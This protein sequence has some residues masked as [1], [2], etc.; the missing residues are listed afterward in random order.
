M[1]EKEKTEQEVNEVNLLINEGIKFKVTYN[2]RKKQGFLKKSVT[3]QI[4]E[5]F[6]IKE[7][8]LDTLDRICAIAVTMV[9]D[10]DELKGEWGNVIANGNKIV[11]ENA[12]KLAKIV[13]IAVLGEN[14]HIKEFSNGKETQRKDDKELDRLCELFYHTLKPSE[15]KNF[16]TAIATTGNIAGFINSIRL[17]SGSRTTQPINRVE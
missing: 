5:D 11:T 4:T 3:E 2:V 14:Y 15:L 8:T 9:L 17:T 16:A 7:P 6:E 13:A 12:R 10:E 1:D